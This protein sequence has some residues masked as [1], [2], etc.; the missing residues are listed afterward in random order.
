MYPV[1]PVDLTPSL[2]EAKVGELLGVRVTVIEAVASEP[3]EPTVELGVT[4]LTVLFDEVE[5]EPAPPR[6]L[7]LLTPNRLNS[8]T[9]APN[10][11]PVA[12]QPLISSVTY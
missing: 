7:V 9:V 1:A 3:T 2:E 4:V 10:S 6:I 5:F 8:A 11:S 12:W